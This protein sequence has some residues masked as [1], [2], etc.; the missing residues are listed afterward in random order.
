MPT[1]SKSVQVDSMAVVAAFQW[2]YENL[3]QKNFHQPFDALTR[4][5]AV[6]D[7]ILSV[8]AMPIQTVF[9]LMKG[10]KVN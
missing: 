2:G 4:P 5:N 7:V 10:K 6:G 8:A 1:I 9:V 3:D